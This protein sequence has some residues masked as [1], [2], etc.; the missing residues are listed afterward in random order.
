M[1]ETGNL[2]DSLFV[3]FHAERS[4]ETL[5]INSQVI[6]PQVTACRPDRDCPA[7]GRHTLQALWRGSQF[8]R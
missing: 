4:D 7:M 6:T 8:S 1:A 3:Q 5:A 2:E